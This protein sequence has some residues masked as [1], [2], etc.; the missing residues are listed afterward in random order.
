MTISGNMTQSEGILQT[1]ASPPVFAQDQYNHILYMLKTA[2]TDVGGPSAHMA[3][4]MRL[5]IFLTR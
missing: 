1:H 5:I 4:F 2:T 3:H